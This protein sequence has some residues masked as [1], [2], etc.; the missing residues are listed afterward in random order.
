MAEL[1]LTT[2]SEGESFTIVWIHE[3]LRKRTSTCESS[4]VRIASCNVP[5]VYA[6]AKH[7][8]KGNLLVSSIPF[9]LLRCRPFMLTLTTLAYGAKVRNYPEP[10]TYRTCCIH[11]YTQFPRHLEIVWIL[12]HRQPESFTSSHNFQSTCTIRLA[13]R[14]VNA[15]GFKWRD[16]CSSLSPRPSCPYVAARI[17]ANSYV[18]LTQTP[19]KH[20]ALVGYCHWMCCS[21]LVILKH[22]HALATS[23]LHNIGIQSIDECWNFPILSVSQSQLPPWSKSPRICAISWQI[24]QYSPVTV[25]LLHK[26]CVLH[27]MQHFAHSCQHTRIWSANL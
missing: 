23:Y 26:G 19:S 1:K 20:F 21:G 11:N 13:F 16:S 22:I 25:Y 24:L 18:S 7:N 6:F 5:N 10:A 3:N 9:Q 27:H 4:R 14:S 8:S 2:F 15:L 17:K 12:L